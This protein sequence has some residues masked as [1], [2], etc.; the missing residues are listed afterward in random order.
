MVGEVLLLP[1]PICLPGELKEEKFLT[2]PGVMFTTY[3]CC[4][5][6]RMVRRPGD[7]ERPDEGDMRYGE[8]WFDRDGDRD[9]ELRLWR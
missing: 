2:L 7:F 8:S 3:G 1:P 5:S 9:G 6:V 4:C